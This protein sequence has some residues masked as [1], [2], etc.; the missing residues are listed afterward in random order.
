M[1]YASCRPLPLFAPVAE[2]EDTPD[3]LVELLECLA[4]LRIELG[5]PR[6]AIAERR[7]GNDPRVH[8]AIERVAALE[9]SL[10]TVG[11]DAAAAH[12]WLRHVR[13]I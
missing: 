2:R 4:D 3:R 10:Q 12:Q 5:R 1:T 6:A 8:D 11:G 7:D 13:L 9:R